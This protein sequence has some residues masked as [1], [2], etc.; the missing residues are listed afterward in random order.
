MSK[1]YRSDAVA[2]NAGLVEEFRSND[3][4][5]SG[6]FANS[7]LLLLTTTGAKTGRER[8]VPLGHWTVDGKLLVIASG[9][10]SQPHPS[11]YHNLRAEP[12]VDV[13]LATPQS[14][15]RFSARAR[16]ATSPEREALW[17]GLL[18]QAPFFAG[19]Q[20]QVSREIPVVVLERR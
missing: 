13:E 14:V 11:W 10:A 7:F 9:N 18:E 12:R 16:V 4:R 17:A 15:D 2:F 8:T 19:H 20:E 1:E 3:G 6:M 5:L